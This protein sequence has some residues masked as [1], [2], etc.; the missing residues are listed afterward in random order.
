MYIVK[1]EKNLSIDL[2]LPAK[3]E[4]ARR[5]ITLTSEEGHYVPAARTMTTW[6]G[7]GGSAGAR[8]CPRR[9]VAPNSGES[10][11]GESA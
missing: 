2:T 5:S 9:E 6:S 1:I 7:E 10:G 11:V 3:K 8:G 4:D